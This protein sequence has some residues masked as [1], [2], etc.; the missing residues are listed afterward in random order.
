MFYRQQQAAPLERVDL[1]ISARAR[2]RRVPLGLPRLRD[3][4][5]AAAVH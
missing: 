5:H 1:R 4:L 3:R 2:R